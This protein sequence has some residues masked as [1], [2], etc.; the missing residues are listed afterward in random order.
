MNIHKF[1]PLIIISIFLVFLGLGYRNTQL[2]APCEGCDAPDIELQ[3]YSGYGWENQLVSSLAEMRGQIVVLNFWASWCV[4]CQK[5]APILEASWQEYA[6]DD[7]IFLGVAWSDTDVAADEFLQKYDITYP[8]SPDI[9][10]QAERLYQFTG[11]PETF[12]IDREGV[13]YK[14]HPGPITEK[15]LTSTLDQMVVMK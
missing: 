10:L 6:D 8:N 5:E 14:Y 11:I 9:Q 3:F 1:V 7:V 15:L 12:F 2:S 13:I 4:P